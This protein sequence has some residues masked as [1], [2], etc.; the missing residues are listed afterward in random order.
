MSTVDPVVLEQQAVEQQVAFDMIRR[1]LP[2]VPVLVVLAGLPWGVAGALS[3]AFAI[4]LVLLNFA[5][6][7]FLL[8][9]AAR[10]SLPT[11]MVAA[12]GGYVLRLALVT[13]AVLAVKDQDWVAMVP[14]GLTLI[15]SHLG[16]LFWETR[17]VSV[18]LA[19][20]G[21]KP[22]REGL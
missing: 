12:L 3:A 1:G 15:V 19:F 4:G 16:L 13:I 18:S 21:L 9:W 14:L 22:S 6:A 17:Y 20:P 10:I 5:L 2:A 8:S 11:L 7:A